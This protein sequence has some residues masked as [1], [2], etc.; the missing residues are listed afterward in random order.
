MLLRRRCTHERPTLPQQFTVYDERKPG[1]EP[2][3]GEVRVRVRVGV[4]VRVRVHTLCGQME[5]M[6]A[7]SFAIVGGC[8][9]EVARMVKEL[10]CFKKQ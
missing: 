2:S 3:C 7:V 4:R 10:G 6:G 8:G 5:Q 9:G 1:R